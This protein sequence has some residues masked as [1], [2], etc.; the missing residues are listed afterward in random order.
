MKK[1]IFVLFLITL[2]IGSFASSSASTNNFKERSTMIDYT[3][4]L[5]TQINIDSMAGYSKVDIEACF[6][7]NIIM[8]Q[9]LRMWQK[10]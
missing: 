5:G 7:K 1:Y 8:L 2:L 3:A 10:M 6:E 9:K 4:K